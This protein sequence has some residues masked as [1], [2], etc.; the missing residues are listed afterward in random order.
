VLYLFFAIALG[1]MVV[2]ALYY[3]FQY[4]PVIA[5]VAIAIVVGIFD[6]HRYEIEVKDGHIIS[7]ELLTPKEWKIA[8]IQS[9]ET[10]ELGFVFY[11][12]L[13]KKKILVSN[14]LAN[15]EDLLSW[16]NQHFDNKSVSDFNV[17][18]DEVIHDDSF[19]QDAVNRVGKVERA[20]FWTKRID[21]LA[22][23]FPILM[24]VLR[25]YA[26][27]F[28]YLNVLFVLGVIVFI[29]TNKGLVKVYDTR[30]DK[31]YFYPN[32]LSALVFPSLAIA[33]FVLLEYD[34]YDFKSMWVWVV[35][36]T[37]LL[38]YMTMQLSKE[39]RFKRWRELGTALLLLLFFAFYA[40]GSLLGINCLS[41]K[42][43]PIA[44]NAEIAD[45]YVADGRVKSHCLKLKPWG[46]KPKE[47]TL[48]N[49]NVDVYNQYKV[50]DSIAL[51]YYPGLLHAGWYK[52]K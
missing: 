9:I 21:I 24:F 46:P 26:A 39:L 51:Y 48:A 41:D 49:L 52:I 1:G 2:N 31:E 12:Q 20:R 33:L 14:Y 42:S 37:L 15:Y 16:A 22:W 34:I 40:V 19:G 43:E 11:S 7:K 3:D 17:E 23:V 8:D 4:F 18:L 5:L 32:A 13:T 50:G 38:T 6:A 36:Y 47:T 27:F 28:F 35:V 10:R 25:D 45:K 29:G 44:Y 30:D